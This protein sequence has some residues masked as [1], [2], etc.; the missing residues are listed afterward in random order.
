MILQTNKGPRGIGA[1]YAVM[2]LLFVFALLTVRA[3][4]VSATSFFPTNNA[5]NVCADTPLKITFDAAPALG[6]TGTVKIFNATTNA[7]VD[8]IDL[9][10]SAG[11]G[12]QARTIGGTSYNVYPVLVSGN[13]AAIFPRAGVL[14]YGATY[15]V[16]VDAGVFTG[17]AG[18]SGNAAWRFTVK[19]GAPSSSNTYLVVAA[20]G[21]GDFCT[22]QGAVDWVPAANTTRRYINVRNGT[23]QEIVRVPSKH[24][25]AFRG[26]HRKRS[27]ISY[28][29]NNNINP[30]TN[31]RPLF[32]V[33]ANDVSFDNLTLSN[34]TPNGGSQAEALRVNGQRCVVANCDVHSYQDTV[35]VN[36]AADT[37]YFLNSLVEGDVDFIWGSGRA[38][39]KGCEIKS[40]AGGYVCQMRNA[41]GQYG[42]VFLDCRFTRAAGVTN[43]VLARIAPTTFPDSAVAVVN[44]A[45][46]AHITSAG[47]L[48]SAAGPTTGLRFWEYQSTD[49]AGA[50]L[51]VSGRA[52]FSTQ[53]SAATAR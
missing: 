38:V 15:Y 40:L 18:V 2:V 21:T 33:V 24:N 48:L 43:V 46:D 29:N 51:N 19:A 34:A 3:A 17:F 27:I 1:G 6:S 26:E 50:A 13:T 4:A 37:A 45:M 20:D 14:T 5:A 9:A 44:C 52:S 28:P 36:G 31:T 10:L 7:V 22:V 16:T 25:L 35:L 8:T 23:Y 41:A 39:F 12:T 32:N 30:S 49:L 42:A 47:W 53:V 11:N